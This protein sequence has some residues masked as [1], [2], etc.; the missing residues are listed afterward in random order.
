MPLLLFVSHSSDCN[1]CQEPRNSG[2]GGALVRPTLIV[3]SSVGKD[4]AAKTGGLFDEKDWKCSSCFNINWA[5]RSS[6]NECKTPRVKAVDDRSGA[7][8]CLFVE[9]VPVFVFHGLNGILF[10]GCSYRWRLQ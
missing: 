1:R 3:A 7:G 8:M 9:L 2:G 6:C 10:V 4:F 5:K